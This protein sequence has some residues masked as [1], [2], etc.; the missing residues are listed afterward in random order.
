MSGSQM[1]TPS[2]LNKTCTMAARVASRGLP[3]A[4]SSAV[5]Q[6]PMLAP[7]ASAIPAGRVIN[8][9]EARTIATPVVA[10]ED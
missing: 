1:R 5:T 10:D 4:A 2:T 8:P 3:M 7:K 6:V 9:W